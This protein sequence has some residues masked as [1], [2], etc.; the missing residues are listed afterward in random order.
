MKKFVAL[1]LAAVMLFSLA[2]CGG[3]GSTTAA[4]ENKNADRVLHLS[5]LAPLTSFDDCQTNNIQD[6]FVTYQTNDFLY[7]M[8]QDTLKIEPGIAES[9]EWNDAGTELTLHIRQ[10]VKF[11]NGKTVTVEDVIFSYNR[12]RQDTHH[13]SKLVKV[14]DVVKVDDKTIKVILSEP[15]AGFM[16]TTGRSVAIVNKEEVEAAGE[17]FGTE[18]HTAGCGP[19]KWGKVE[20]MDSY[21]E[22]EAFED[23]WMG[24]PAIKKVAYTPIT[25]AS[26]GLIKFE[27]GELDW[28][29]APMA[30]WDDLKAN[31]KYNTELVAAN[32][33]SYMILHYTNGELQDINLRKAIAYA[34]NKD[35][36][37]DVAYQGMAK[38]APYMYDPDRNVA[39]PKHD[40]T[41]SYN[42]EKAKEY[43]A[44]SNMPNGGKLSGFLQVSAG[45]YFEK[46]A[47]VVAENL[48]A[49]G[50]EV[51]VHP[52]QSATHMELM[53][54]GNFFMGISGGSPSGDYSGIASWYF[55]TSAFARFDDEEDKNDEFD[56]AWMQETFAKGNGA[57]TVEERTKY[58][59]ELDAYVMDRAVYIPIFH[60]VQP[61]VWTKDLNIPVNYQDFYVLRE[62]SWK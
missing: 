33:Q 28:Y 3:S 7:T 11:H 43:L 45:G 29:I 39:A 35:A 22:L 38:I 6:E 52:M 57:K 55:S 26:A 30:N 60:K 49:I 19:Y 47:T 18:P 17:K 40:T 42:L 51:E 58:Y 12:S 23:Y 27:A 50:L 25:Q 36:C 2:A 1:I 48:K 4:P 13:K 59:A 16:T 9:W 31:D 54:E 34:V 44:K 61:Y 8:N 46:I 21:W 10:G 24:A 62:W 41:Y 5:T 15:D 20:S 32:H 37:N 14:T 56:Y 53:R